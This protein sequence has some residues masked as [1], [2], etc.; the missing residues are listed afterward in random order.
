VVV[1][2]DANRI[3]DVTDAAA[4]LLGWRRSDLAGERLAAIVPPRFRDAHL[5]GFTRYL[6]TGHARLIGR[7]ATVPAMRA[8]GSEVEVT[9]RLQARPAGGRTLFV[10]TLEATE[11]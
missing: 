11:H 6:A 1:A 8:D 5:A 9:L 2:D 7:V 10:A 3:V 4:D